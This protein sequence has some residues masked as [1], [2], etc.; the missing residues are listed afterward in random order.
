MT[1]RSKKA[2]YEYGARGDPAGLKRGRSIACAGRSP[3]SAP[4]P[5]NKLGLFAPHASGD[6]YANEPDDAR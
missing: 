6:D 4:R 5:S 2:A 1:I 3:A